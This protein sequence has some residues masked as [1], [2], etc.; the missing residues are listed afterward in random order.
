[1]NWKILAAGLVVVLPLVALLASGFGKDPQV[2]PSMLEGREAP[3]FAL[4]DLDGGGPVRLSA[5]DGPVVL[6]FWASW[7][8][9]CLYEHPVLLE[10][11][12]R[13]GPRGVH[14]YGVLYGDEVPK[15]KAW[16]RRH[17]QAY[18]TLDDADGRVALDYGVGGV[19]ETFVIDRDGHVRLKI[20]GPADPAA[21]FAALDGV[22]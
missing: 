14:F 9:P 10:A 6:N 13:Y 8:Q 22:L 21:L 5:L 4:A 11:S 19:P 17:G 2:L 16:L 7:C 1:M 15:A 20:V 3:E 12:K 18:P